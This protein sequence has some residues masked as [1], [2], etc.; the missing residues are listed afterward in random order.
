VG[1]LTGGMD[2]VAPINPPT[3]VFHANSHLVVS[4]G[5]ASGACARLRDRLGVRLGQREFQALD[6]GLVELA[7]R[8]GHRDGPRLGCYDLRN[9]YGR[10]N[11]EPAPVLLV[12]GATEN[13][14]Q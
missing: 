12:A 14:G 9:S 7:M 4:A 11:A 5:R 6:V 2:W 3:R 10:R 1:P 8:E 13:V